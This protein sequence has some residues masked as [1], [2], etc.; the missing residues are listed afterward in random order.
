MTN[1]P[2]VCL[3]RKRKSAMTVSM[4]TNFAAGISDK[5]LTHEEVVDAMAKSSCACASSS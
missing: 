3:A 5:P 2:E 1:V 4:V